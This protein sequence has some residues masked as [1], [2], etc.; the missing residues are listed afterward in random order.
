MTAKRMGHAKDSL[1][2]QLRPRLHCAP[3]VPPNFNRSGT[4]YE[5]RRIVPLLPGSVAN[6]VAPIAH[7]GASIWFGDVFGFLE[8]NCK[9]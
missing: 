1:C 5:A 2:V 7:C 4:R 3:T 8:A 9:L 6:N